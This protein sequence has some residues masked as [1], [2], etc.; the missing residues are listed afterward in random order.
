M[1][2]RAAP[3]QKGGIYM[4]RKAASEID[5]L[6]LEDDFEVEEEEEE[7]TKPKAKKEGPKGVGARQMADE[8]GADAKTF[9]AWL[10][11]KIESGDIEIDH[12]FKG[13]YNFG[14]TIN[15]PMAKKVI[16]MWGSESHEKGVGL[17]KAHAQAKAK[18]GT[19]AKKGGT[20][21]KKK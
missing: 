6:E 18:K 14:T 8:V 13:R 15:S 10:R 3:P 11:R 16:K 20:K 19:A 5:E 2:V 7:K 12:E 21:P 9:R 1:I 17:K 4:P